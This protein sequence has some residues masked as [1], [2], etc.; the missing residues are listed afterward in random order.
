MNGRGAGNEYVMATTSSSFYSQPLSGLSPLSLD[1][2]F[3]YIAHLVK[4]PTLF[5]AGKHIGLNTLEEV[6]EYAKA[7]PRVLKYGGTGNVSDDAILMYMINELT[8]IEL[9]YVPYN[10]GAEVLAA[11]LGGH[12][13]FAVYHLLKEENILKQAV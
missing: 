11:I 10:S 12:K 5:A 13:M 9:V 7:N 8:G 2:D 3:T 6:I 4:D 1:D